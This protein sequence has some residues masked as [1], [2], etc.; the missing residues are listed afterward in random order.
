M[1]VLSLISSRL[2]FRHRRYNRLDEGSIG[3][4]AQWAI[5]I[6]CGLISPSHVLVFFVDNRV[7]INH[8]VFRTW[9]SVVFWLVAVLHYLLLSRCRSVNFL[10]HLSPIMY[11]HSA[12]NTR[13][14]GRLVSMR[15]EEG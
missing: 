13:T 9:Q 3:F 10:Y 7:A 2:T 8:V 11:Q 15:S 5:I 1:K 6:I 14:S 12:F 4:I